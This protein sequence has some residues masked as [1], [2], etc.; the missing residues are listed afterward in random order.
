MN[1]ESSLIAYYPFNGNANDE[2]SNN[3][4]GTV[5]GATLTADKDGNANCAYHF[6]GDDHIEISNFGDIVPTEEITVSMWIKSE[7]SRA[8]FQLTLCPDNN[9]FAVSVNYYHAGQ[10]TNF[11]DFGW[12]GEGGN[13][14]GR[15][16]YRPETHDTDWH[17]YVFVSSISQSKQAIYK[18]GVLQ[19]SESTPRALQN[20]AGKAL[21]IGSNDG[22][23][24]HIGDI[25]E[26]KIFNR[27]LSAEEIMEIYNE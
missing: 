2:S 13:P 8:Q 18:D 26:V 24:Y 3:N 19:I 27:A 10:N 14:P 6:D 11:W 16:Y 21:K 23:G 5:Y 4:N 1:E 9:R 25:D 22:F 12:L 7:Q 15:T 17:H 20:T